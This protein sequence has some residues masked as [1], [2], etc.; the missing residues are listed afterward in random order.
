[1]INYSTLNI[2]SIVCDFT[3]TEVILG[4][5]TEYHSNQLTKNL[6]LQSNLQRITEQVLVD[7]NPQKKVSFE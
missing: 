4:K 7:R 6:I 3:L 2:Y 1:M 5:F